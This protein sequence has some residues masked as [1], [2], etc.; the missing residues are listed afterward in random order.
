MS[1]RRRSSGQRNGQ[2][3][4]QRQQQRSQGRN[5]KGTPARAAGG[6]QPAEFWRAA[7]LTDEVAPVPAV[8]DPTALL[9]SLGT[10]PLT[11]QGAVADHYLAA[12]VARAASLSSA[13]AAAT[14]LLDS[15]E[16]TEPG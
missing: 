16:D 2:R 10:P 5:G 11:G 14:G 4:G 15:G 12:V 1:P 7:P 8:A 6:P 3:N 9:R 13:L